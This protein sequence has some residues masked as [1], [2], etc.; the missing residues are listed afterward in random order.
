MCRLLKDISI[1][2]QLGGQN[3]WPKPLTNLMKYIRQITSLNYKPNGNSYTTGEIWHWGPIKALHSMLYTGLHS[4]SGL[5]ADYT[6]YYFC[7]PKWT[8]SGPGSVVSIATAYG[9]DGLVIESRWGWDFPRLS[10]LAEAHLAS[11]TMGTRSFPG[12]RCGQGACWPLN[13]F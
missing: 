9:L 4:F 2:T 12:V 10:R 1:N 3:R 7:R 11:C 5:V 13:P 8:T 6:A